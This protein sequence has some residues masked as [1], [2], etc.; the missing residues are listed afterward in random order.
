V[1]ARE[2]AARRFVVFA[3]NHDQTG[4]RAQGERLAS[5]VD[6]ERLKLA[7]GA[8][9]LSPYLPLLFMGEEYGEER[10]FLYFVSHGDPELVAAVRRGRAEEFA[11]VGRQGEAP[12]PQAA[13]TFERSR[14]DR[15]AAERPENAA[16]LELHREL[17][18]LRRDVPALARLANDDLAAGADEAAGVLHLLREAEGSRAF[19][20]FNFSRE[21][22]RA[23][24]LPAGRW[25]RLIDSAAERWA[26]AT[27]IAS[28]LSS[29][30]GHSSLIV[31]ES[32]CQFFMNMPITS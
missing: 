8:V 14:L 31:T 6:G 9:L 7:A 13:E 10:P 19:A 29:S 21:P 18:R 20:V 5:L 24:L 23:A 26:G 12:D 3:Q 27:I 4:N 16:L 15:G 25:R 1:P 30:Q 17:L 32:S 22:R 28:L 2:V 11:A